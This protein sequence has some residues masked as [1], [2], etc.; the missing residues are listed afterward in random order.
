[1]TAVRRLRRGERGGGSRG[2][3]RGAV[4]VEFALIAP[5]LLM[6]VFGIIDFGW[7]IDRSN[8]VN[9]V[10][11]D[12]ARTASLDGTYSQINTVATD[13]LKD[14][15]VTLGSNATLTVTCTNPD[16]TTCTSVN[17][18]AKAISGSAVKVTIS[19]KHKWITPVGAICGFF[20]GGSCTGNTIQL[21]RTSE[22]VRE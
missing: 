14:I 13:E 7:M 12:A 22:M 21:T 17:Y 4:I 10:A 6:L 11:R 8:V 18:D 5:L 1:V 16:G 2:S 3:E 9:N 20:G 15:G 19:Y